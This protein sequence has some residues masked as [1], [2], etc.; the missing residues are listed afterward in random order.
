MTTDDSAELV[1]ALSSLAAYERPTGRVE[2]RQTHI[3]W[4]FFLDDRVYKVKKPVDLGF[5]DFSTLGRRK[6]ACDDEVRLNRRLAGDVYLGVVPITRGPESRLRVGGSGEALEWAVEMIRLPEEGMLAQRLERGVIDNEPM[7]ALAEL[8]V[9]F[10]ATSATGADVDE[11]GRPVAIRRNVLE[12]FEE[13]APFVGDLEGEHAVLTRPQHAF[14]EG[15]AR[16]FLDR[17]GDLFER[18]IREHRI[19][20]GHGDL[21]AENLCFVDGRVVAYDCIEFSRAFRC[22]DVAADL[23]F[24]AMDL[25]YRGFPGF[26]SYLVRRYVELGGDGEL[27]LLEAFYK[28]YRAIVRAKVSALTAADEG[29]DPDQRVALRHKAMRYVQLAAAYELPAAMILLCGPPAEA[30]RRLAGDLAGSLR[31]AVLHF[32]VHERVAAARPAS[33]HRP[34]TVEHRTYRALLA[35][36]LR[37]LRAGHSVIV[38]AP[39]DRREHRSAFVDAAA[40]LDLPYYV[41]PLETGE[42]HEPPDEVPAAHLLPSVP[43]G[44]PSVEPASRLID[45]MIELAAS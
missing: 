12:N 16:R 28:G 22:G 17:N 32:A 7:N 41:L 35:G 36:A 29:V 15:R 24:L 44:A 11:H 5:L 18:R 3:S 10:H 34:G 33:A 21:H 4:L 26:S 14:L 45:R 31:A 23:A 20:E 19:R 37:N 42:A 13:L 43:A 30:K 2:L 8:L 39:F 38:D 6:Q 40:R 25:D 27:P 9:P 1:E